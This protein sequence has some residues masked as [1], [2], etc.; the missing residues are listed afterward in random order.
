MVDFTDHGFRDCAPDDDDDG[1]V[2]PLC[3]FKAALA[4]FLETAAAGHEGHWDA[5]VGGLVDQM[6]NATAALHRLRRERFTDE[7]DDIANAHEAAECLATILIDVDRLRR[8]VMDDDDQGD[9]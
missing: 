4:E 1:A 3:A 7:H 2:C 9:E 8:V 6:H 5:A